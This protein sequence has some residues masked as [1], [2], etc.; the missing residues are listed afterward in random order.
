MTKAQ[1]SSRKHNE[2]RFLSKSKVARKQTPGIY[3]RLN[4]MTQENEH[5]QN[6]AFRRQNLAAYK[7]AKRIGK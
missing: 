6:R 1:K 4:E 7:R 5:K 3:Y 2:C